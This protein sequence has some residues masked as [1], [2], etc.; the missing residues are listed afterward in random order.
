MRVLCTALVLYLVAM[1]AVAAAAVPHLGLVIAFFGSINGSLLALI[2]PPLLTVCSGCEK[3]WFWLG[4]HT[5]I[6][7]MGSLGAC[8]GTYDAAL[9]IMEAQ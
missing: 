9:Q 3:R 7:V 1:T 2:F 8:I 4:L 5:S 6:A